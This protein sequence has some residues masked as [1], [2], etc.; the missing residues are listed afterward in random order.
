MRLNEYQTK[1]LFARYGVPIPRGRVASNSR[2]V[3]QITEEL[4]GQVVIKAQV[5]VHGRGRLGGI[6]I[7][8]STQEAELQAMRILG[9]PL[10][11]QPVNKVLVDELISFHQQ[12]YLSIRTDYSRSEERRVGKECRSRWSPYH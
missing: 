2:E 10:G 8:R 6:R 3:A 4:G 1:Q 5:L 11:N 7:A 9:S 12:Y